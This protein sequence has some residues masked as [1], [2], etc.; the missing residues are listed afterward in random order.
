[1]LGF[2]FVTACK[3]IVAALDY[4]SVHLIEKCFQKAG[5][6][7]SVLT[8]HEAEGEPPRNIWDNM[9]QVMKVQVP[10]ADYT[11]ADNAVEMTEM[12][13]DADI[14]NLVKGRNQ[15]EEEED[16]DDDVISSSGSVSDNTTAADESEIIHTSTQFVCIIAQQKAYVLRNKLSLSTL[17]ALNTIEQSVLASKLKSC[18]TQTSLLS[19]LTVDLLVTWILLNK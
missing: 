9:Q 19:F 18:K 8:A 4:V 3:N 11:T 12:L 14:V 16:P 15:T 1:M 5:L 13:S 10:F 7:C 6:I 17:N 2:N